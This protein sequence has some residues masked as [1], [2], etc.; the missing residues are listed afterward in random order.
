M[1]GKNS[2][3]NIMGTISDEYPNIIII[4]THYNLIRPSRLL[5]T[6]IINQDM[7]I[8]NR[9]CKVIKYPIKYKK[10]DNGKH[11][12]SNYGAFSIDLLFLIDRIIEGNIGDICRI[13]LPIE[14]DNNEMYY[15]DIIKEIIKYTD[16]RILSRFI[17][18]LNEERKS[19]KQYLINTY[20]SIYDN[21]YSDINTQTKKSYKMLQARAWNWWAYA[22]ILLY[23]NKERHS[24]QITSIADLFK[25]MKMEV[26]LDNI[27]GSLEKLHHRLSE[28]T[29]SFSVLNPEQI[30]SI[31]KKLYDYRRQIIKVTI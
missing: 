17:H 20:N 19:I 22:A 5:F 7:E 2:I 8:S 24:L 11:Q 18:A 1:Y 27:I 15:S 6:H 25:Y 26:K 9:Y 31:R 16:I 12:V 4:S 23:I 30:D 3:Y 14:N 13:C 10:F 21:A 29:E 28:E